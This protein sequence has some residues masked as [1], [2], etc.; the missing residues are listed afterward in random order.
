[1]TARSN[2]RPRLASAALLN[3]YAAKRNGAKLAKGGAKGNERTTAKRGVKR[4]ATTS[5][6]TSGNTAKVKAVAVAPLAAASVLR[7]TAALLARWKAASAMTAAVPPTLTAPAELAPPLVAAAS[8]VVPRSV[9]LSGSPPLASSFAVV[10]AVDADVPP[11]VA[12]LDT[13]PLVAPPIAPPIAPLGAPLA[14]TF[15]VPAVNDDVPPCVAPLDAA[16]VAPTLVAPLVAPPIAPLGAPLAS[17]FAVP[18][19]NDDVPPCVAPLDAARVAPTLVAPLVAPPIAPLGAP[20]ASSFAVPAVNDDVPPCVA[21]LDAARVA[22]TLV[23]PLVAPP[24]APLGAPLASTFAVPAV[25]D[26]VPPC[27]APLDAARVAPTLVAPLVAPPIAPLGAPL[28]STFA[29]PAVNDDVP[30]CVAPLDAAR[31]APT[32][33]APLVAPPIAPLGAPLASTFAV[34]AVNDDV[35]PCVA[36]LDAARVAPTLVA[37]LVA[38]PIAP[39]GA[40]LASTFAVVP[41]VDADVPPCVAPLD[42]ARVAPTLV[43]PLVAP[44]IAPLGAPLASTFAVPAVNDDVPPCVAPLDAARVSSTLT[45]ESVP[46]PLKKNASGPKKLNE[47]VTGSATDVVER[48]C[49]R[50]TS[51]HLFSDVLTGLHASLRGK[52]AE[53]VTA[54][55]NLL[56]GSGGGSIGDAAVE[57]VLCLSAPLGASYLELI[58]AVDRSVP[59]HCVFAVDGASQ[60]RAKQA[61]TLSRQAPVR[62]ILNKVRGLFTNAHYHQPQKVALLWQSFAALCPLLTMQSPVVTLMLAAVATV[63]SGNDETVPLLDVSAQGTADAT[64]DATANDATADADCSD[65]IS[66]LCASLHERLEEH[67]KN[68]RAT[69]QVGAD[70]AQRAARAAALVRGGLGVARRAT[71]ASPV[72]SDVDADTGGARASAGGVGVQRGAA[73]TTGGGAA[74]RPS[75]VGVTVPGEG[76]QFCAVMAAKVAVERRDAAVLLCSSDTDIIV[77]AVRQVEL[78][79]RGDNDLMQSA[80]GRIVIVNGRRAAALDDIVG[81][82]R[83]QFEGCHAVDIYLAWLMM[84]C[85]TTRQIRPG[86]GFTTAMRELQQLRARTA[87]P[88]DD[89]AE[90]NTIF[91]ALGVNCTESFA[92]SVARHER[93]VAEVASAVPLVRRWI[94]QSSL[95]ATPTAVG[96][97]PFDLA[98]GDAVA[99]AMSAAELLRD[100]TSHHSGKR[101]AS[102]PTPASPNERRAA[103]AAYEP[104]DLRVSSLSVVGCGHALSQSVPCVVPLLR[105]AKQHQLASAHAH[106]VNGKDASRKGK[107]VVEVAPRHARVCALKSALARSVSG[108]ISAETANRFR[109]LTP[110]AQDNQKGQ[111]RPGTVQMRQHEDVSSVAHELSE[112][113]TLQL[114]A[115]IDRTVALKAARLPRAAS[116]KPLPVQLTLL[117]PGAAGDV[118]DPV[119]LMAVGLVGL[120]YLRVIC[121]VHHGERA[122]AFRVVDSGNDSLTFAHTLAGGSHFAFLTFCDGYHKS[123]FVGG[124]LRPE[125]RNAR[126][127]V[128]ALSAQ[129][130]VFCQ[131]SVESPTSPRDLAHSV[132]KRCGVFS[133]LIDRSA[134]LLHKP[135][136][137]KRARA[138]LG[139][140]KMHGPPAQWQLLTR[141]RVETIGGVDVHNDGYSVT[142]EV[143]VTSAVDPTRPFQ[144]AFQ[145]AER[146][147]DADATRFQMAPNQKFEC[148]QCEIEVVFSLVATAQQAQAPVVVVVETNTIAAASFSLDLTVAVCDI[149]LAANGSL[150]GGRLDK[151]TMKTASRMQSVK[152]LAG[153]GCGTRVRML[154]AGIALAAGRQTAECVAVLDAGV[155]IARAREL[156]GEGATTLKSVVNEMALRD[157]PLHSNAIVHA[158][159]TLAT[160]DDVCSRNVVPALAGVIREE[161]VAT[162]LFDGSG[163]TV[164]RAL[165]RALEKTLAALVDV[166]GLKADD[167]DDAGDDD[168]TVVVG[169]DEDEDEDDQRKSAR[170]AVERRLRRDV[171][172]LNDRSPVKLSTMALADRRLLIAALN[173]RLLGVHEI[174]GAERAFGAVARGDAD[175]AGDAV[176]LEPVAAVLSAP[177]LQQPTPSAAARTHRFDITPVGKWFGVPHHRANAEP[178]RV[179]SALFDN[180]WTNVLAALTTSSRETARVTSIQTDGGTASL[181][182]ETTKAHHHDRPERFR[183]DALAA[184]LAKAEAA[185]STAMLN[186]LNGV[187]CD[188]A[189]RLFPARSYMAFVAEAIAARNRADGIDLLRMVTGKASASTEFFGLGKE[190]FHWLCERPLAP[191]DLRCGVQFPARLFQSGL[192]QIR[193][194]R[195]VRNLIECVRVGGDV[196]VK[197]LCTFVLSK[198]VPPPP[199]NGDARWPRILNGELDDTVFDSAAID[200]LLSECS[201]VAMIHAVRGSRRGRAALDGSSAAGAAAAAALAAAAG[202]TGGVRAMTTERAAAYVER[203]AEEYEAL[204]ADS[205]QRAVLGAR[206][207]RVNGRHQR[208]ARDVNALAEAVRLF[209]AYLVTNAAECR[210]VDAAR[211]QLLADLMLSSSAFDART[212]VF[213]GHQRTRRASAGGGAHPRGHQ[214]SPMHDY[215]QAVAKRFRCVT[216]S[217]CFT[218]QKCWQCGEQLVQTR[219][220]RYK[221]CPQRHRDAEEN[222]DVIAA[223]AMLRIG[224]VLLVDGSRPIE[225]CSLQLRAFDL[226]AGTT[227]NSKPPD[228]PPPANKRKRAEEED[229]E[230]EEEEDKEE[231]DEIVLSLSDDDDDENAGNIGVDGQYCMDFAHFLSSNS[232]FYTVTATATHSAAAV[233]QSAESG[234]KPAQL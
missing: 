53:K 77:H 216:A 172:G 130:V 181:T 187:V 119:M 201:S 98:P 66:D 79:C 233:L 64:A 95:A 198:I 174:G 153:A 193:T 194:G 116:T 26:D 9:P 204:T 148:G 30:P 127:V 224:T 28:A 4:T 129:D 21:P 12:P 120:Q 86:V 180:R 157:V 163:A 63:V 46:E 32:L 147:K 168:G 164:K 135:G 90:I 27:V 228:P 93:A 18:A 232:W 134:E 23:A 2:A 133:R 192:V 196:G 31:V 108:K 155:T 121:T 15:A 197:V 222:R 25:N 137:K 145:K 183:V 179:L 141:G 128:D 146:E 80:L 152:K 142:L 43:A 188:F 208:R 205:M 60:T 22:P 140:I 217:E 118:L 158:T 24:I 45:A 161:L 186:Y 143:T 215:V 207:L 221:R 214:A 229:K 94:R 110:S 150:S 117:Q 170:E 100:A 35:P 34:P 96:V 103:A 52:K 13:A 226:A 8:L 87:H 200:H 115:R 58:D 206:R 39:L 50:A 160:N 209:R 218:S 219:S 84:G 48:V 36:P 74:R 14:S 92:D 11:C 139:A 144:L 225:W 149:D 171:A 173:E 83:R 7:A 182:F 213:L 68:G 54:C 51:I 19:V 227:A 57:Q 167:G 47:L 41:A 234:G 33:V 65:V 42:A 102:S 178:V 59:V 211:H 91:R 191:S 17:T 70:V 131:F 159:S 38:P 223:F 5:G 202:V 175:A 169:D 20:L 1:V 154:P 75:S 29:V 112:Q 185:S 138:E 123:A 210:I 114:Q 136:D 78:E 97:D 189:R 16:R 212:V 122:Q 124:Q 126:A 62:T 56:V 177:Y 176:A 125:A 99:A 184:A 162:E 166:T 101:G 230:E 151:F 82:L 109:E 49:A 89:L 231:E 73:P 3:Q 67:R 72:S 37:P 69:M 132:V 44:P 81:S 107:P 61:T 165:R 55:L 6:A 76:E 113:A 190:A 88:V 40:P 156:R 105:C 203:F 220:L 199:E 71:E 111:H 10:P 104:T 106:F 85:D 195:D